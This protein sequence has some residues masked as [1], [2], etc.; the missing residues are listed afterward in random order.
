VIS[1]RRSAILVLAA[2]AVALS[3]V[4]LVALDYR[5]TR[6][7]LV[8][9]LREQAHALRESVAAAAR[10]NRAA[11]VFAASQLGE[12]LLDRARALAELDR[13]GRLTPAAVRAA[14]ETEPLL[15][16]AL[17]APDGSR[18]DRAAGPPSDGERGGRGPR[19]G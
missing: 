12:R 19:A 15:R 4:G 9:L 7:E 3:F 8:G 2:T 10:S 6:S 1:A 11:S 16:I 13:L 18:E 17:F 5:A 14:S